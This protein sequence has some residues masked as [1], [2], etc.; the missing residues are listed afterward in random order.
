MN[1]TI[2]TNG[3]PWLLH[4]YIGKKVRKWGNKDFG[5]GGMRPACLFSHTVFF[6]AKFNHVLSVPLHLLT[7]STEVS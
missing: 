4:I 6:L 3:I 1:V 7:R 5:G 2:W